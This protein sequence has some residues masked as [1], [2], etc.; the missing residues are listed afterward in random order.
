V[1]H[2]RDPEPTGSG[3]TRLLLDAPF[4]GN[5]VYNGLTSPANMRRYLEAAFS[6]DRLVTPPLVE[7]YVRD[8]RQPGGK[9]SVAALM[10]GVLNVDVRVAL[11]RVRQPALMLWGGLARQNSVEHAHAF[12]VLKHD[13]SWSLIQEAGDLPHVERP[14]EVNAALRNFLERARRWSTPT[15]P[16]LV[17]T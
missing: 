17:M 2:L 6:D 1:A 4:V 16:R 9:H 11:R 5:R 7:T 13:L 3:T 12:R 8:A 14:D 10:S 15:G